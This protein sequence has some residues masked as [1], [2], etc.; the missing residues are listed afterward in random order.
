MQLYIAPKHILSVPIGF[1]TKHILWVLIGIVL[2]SNTSEYWQS[3]RSTKV[4]KIVLYRSVVNYTYRIKSTEHSL[5]SLK[6]E[7]PSFLSVVCSLFLKAIF[8][9]FILLDI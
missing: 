6:T 3:V 4:T 7:T 5:F 9:T 8:L 2:M 1:A